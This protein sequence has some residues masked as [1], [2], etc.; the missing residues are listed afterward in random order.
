MEFL[1]SPG[2]PPLSAG[3]VLACVCISYHFGL[4]SFPFFLIIFWQVI[5][6]VDLTNSGKVL[7][8]FVNV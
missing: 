3:Q 1:S 7:L 8:C 4:Y 6:L 5:L 2:H